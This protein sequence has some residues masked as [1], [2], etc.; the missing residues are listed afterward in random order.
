MNERAAGKA[1]ADVA[2]HAQSHKEKKNKGKWNKNG[3]N[4]QQ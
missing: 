3:G 1:K 4:H 2:L